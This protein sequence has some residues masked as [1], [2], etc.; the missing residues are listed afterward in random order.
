MSAPNTRYPP[1]DAATLE[2]ICGAVVALRLWGLSVRTFHNAGTDY[3]DRCPLC[4]TQLVWAHDRAGELVITPDIF[5]CRQCKYSIAA[6]L[7]R[8]DA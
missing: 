8:I 5:E 4:D 3:L 1:A 6:E 2:R 7:V